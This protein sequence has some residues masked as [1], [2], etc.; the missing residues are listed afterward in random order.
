MR[1]LNAGFRWMKYSWLVQG[2]LRDFGVEHAYG[3]MLGIC[4][5]QLQGENLLVLDCR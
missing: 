2:G 3:Q 5:E 1:K 4:I